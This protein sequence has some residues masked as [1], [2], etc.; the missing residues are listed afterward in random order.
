VAERTF[1]FGSFVMNNPNGAEGHKARSWDFSVLA[2]TVQE[3][4]RDAEP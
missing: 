4:E 2:G 3:E 1:G